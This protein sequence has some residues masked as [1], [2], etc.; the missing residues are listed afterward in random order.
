MMEMT[1]EELINEDEVEYDEDDGEIS[2]LL[3]KRNRKPIF[4]LILYR[5]SEGH[6]EHLEETSR[7]EVRRALSTKVKP[8]SVIKI[9]R[10]S[11]IMPLKQKITYSI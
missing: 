4:Y 7:T 10:V 3:P 11:G 5:N 8:D 1:Q 2:P 6:I 9:Y